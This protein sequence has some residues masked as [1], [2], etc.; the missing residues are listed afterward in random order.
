MYSMVYVQYGIRTVWCMYSMVYVQYGV[1]TVWCRLIPLHINIH[2]H[3]LNTVEVTAPCHLYGLC[4]GDVIEVLYAL[5]PL[6]RRG[7]VK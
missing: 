7:S 2:A 5:S 4:C 3:H 1:C 6:M